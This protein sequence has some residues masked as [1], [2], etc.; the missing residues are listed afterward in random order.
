MSGWGS[1]KGP[2]AGA[3]L[4]M[5]DQPGEARGLVPAQPRIHGIRVA[6]FQEPMSGHAMG[7]L[8]LG[9]LEHRGATLPGVGAIVVVT[10]PKE[11]LVLLFGQDQGSAAQGWLPVQ[12]A[13]MED[14]PIIPDLPILRVKIH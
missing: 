13:R 11:F 8:A 2:P 5:G 9:D 4:G 14:R 10:Q 12:N 6:W 1:L 3:T 7:G